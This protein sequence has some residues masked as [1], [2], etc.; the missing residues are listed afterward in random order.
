MPADAGAHVLVQ[1]AGLGCGFVRTI[2][3]RAD[4]A[5][6]PAGLVGSLWKQYDSFDR[7]QLLLYNGMTEQ[8][9][10]IKVENCLACLACNSQGKCLLVVANP[11]PARTACKVTIDARRLNIKTASR[12]V[13]LDRGEF[14]AFVLE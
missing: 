4:L 5:A 2:A 9:G 13:D 11:S 1:A 10:T 14:H 8:S 6:A 12:T 7:E 3:S